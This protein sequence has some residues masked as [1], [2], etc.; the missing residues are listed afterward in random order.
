MVSPETPGPVRIGVLGG[1]DIA[2]RR[3]LPALAAEPG[4]RLVAVASRSYDKAVRFTE[5]FGGDPVDGYE[6]L[7]D[8]PDVDAVY[9]PLPAALH[10]RW[11]RQ[12]LE[13]GK[14]VLAEKPMTLAPG[15]TAELL[16]LARRRGLVLIEN[17]MFTRHSQHQK[18]RQLLA[19]GVIG[20]P[21][22]FFSAFTVPAR[23]AGDIRLR[24]DLGGGALADVGG[25]PISAAC[26]ILGRQFRVVGA[27]LRR[28]P[29]TNVDTSGTALLINDDGVP[30]Q[31]LFGMEHAYH[32]A[33]EVWGST[34]RL[35]LNHA[36]APQAGHRPIVRI[37]DAQGV[38]ERVLEAD[39]QYRNT[40]RAFSHAV[41][42]AAGQEAP[43][44]PVADDEAAA[45]LRRAV[46]MHEI[47][48]AAAIEVSQECDVS[49]HR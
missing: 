27:T 44:Q 41:R 2:W 34:G 9:V 46:L 24:A 48:G 26:L 40:W 4:A 14:H 49:V 43:A 10:A 7:L 17:Y 45:T 25:Y 36:F 11:I 5:R 20:R 35:V 22:A 39:D 16:A 13:R 23:P 18:V 47:A 33:Y 32:A 29:E 12:A 15:E 30:A 19:A 3:V 42:R 6:R 38:T 37:H 28:D 1:A 21:R 8:R 31:L